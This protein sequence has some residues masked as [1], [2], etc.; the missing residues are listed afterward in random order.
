MR[1]DFTLAARSENSALSSA[2]LECGGSIRYN[3]LM[4][5]IFDYLAW[6]GDLSFRQSPLNPVDALI[7]SQLSYLAFD[8]IVPAPGEDSEI[9]ISQ[10]AQIFTKKHEKNALDGFIM[11]KDDP[12]FLKTLGKT[13][14]FKDCILHSYVN[15]IDEKLEKQFSAVCVYMEPETF[16]V[17][18]GTDVSL[19]G[20]KEDLNMSFTDAVP[21]QLEAVSYL[22]TAAENT[23]GPLLV[24]GHSKGGNLAV[25][26]ASSAAKKIHRR[27]TAIY[28][29]D[30][31]GFHRHLIESDGFREIKEKITLYIPQSSVVGML[32]EHGK[33]SVVIKSSE[34]GLLQH[35]LYSW[36]ITC[37]DMVRLDTLTQSS[38]FVDN[39]LK[40]WMNSMDYEHRR[41]FIE[42]LYTILSATQAK[43][44]FDFG[45]D[46]FKTAG[47][48]IQTL[49][50]IDNSTKKVIKRTITALFKAAKNNF[51]AMLEPAVKLKTQRLRRASGSGRKSN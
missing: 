26:A 14:R 47:K 20:W 41:Q 1:S 16:V 10:A 38:R 51:E 32:F 35:E 4:A 46:W 33:D 24:G 2:P 37:N 22:E 12:E 50:N 36:E 23:T 17:F 13:N 29:F 6:R 15:H 7:F 25:Y 27:I 45:T 28:S 43:S 31:P 42:A 44:V 40:D 8:N 5:H 48:M 21:A 49:G 30:A 11:F 34:Y 9:S 18:R 3:R 19:V 39:T